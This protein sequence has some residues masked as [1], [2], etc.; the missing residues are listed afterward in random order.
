MTP[1]RKR[2]L[3]ALVSAALVIVALPATGAHA[4]DGTPR[5]D[6]LTLA[7]ER[8]DDAR[9]SAAELAEKISATQTEQG[10]LEAQIAEAERTIPELR[11]R[12][13]VL[14]LVVKQRAVQLY[15]GRDHRI[16]AVLQT[17]SVV[18]G[19]R[20]AQLTGTIATHDRDVAAELRETADELETR[21]A[22]LRTQHAQLRRAIDALAPLNEALQKRLAL[23]T[24]V[25]EQVRSAL[26]QQRRS[27]AVSD[28]STGATRCPVAGFVV[29]TDDFG[30][31]RPGDRLHE[32]IDMP[33]VE[34]T[35]VVAVVD[36]FLRHDVGG[37][38]GNGA[39]LIGTDQVAYYY[40]HFSRYEG[41][42]GFVGA[43]EVIGYVG[44]TG[45]A[46]GPHLHFE[47]HPGGGPP[48]DGYPLLL[49]LCAEETALALG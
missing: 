13:D 26:D 9:A 1:H 2:P 46:T 14:R 11:G 34:G 29:F 6:A 47:V 38:G 37:A 19:A 45:D 44:M 40:A 32:G 35:P 41:D 28:A 23:A 48:I 18:D 30:E 33:A 21:E 3:L 31:P 36:G 22:Q 39:W 12:A 27:G 16:D 15:V 5:R 24:K 20:A 43:G 25:Y 17:D 42:G 7:R 49:T 4:D 8:L 10:R